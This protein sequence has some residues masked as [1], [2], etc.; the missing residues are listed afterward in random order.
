MSNPYGGQ[1]PYGRPWQPSSPQPGPDAPQSSNG[2]SPQ[3]AA[4]PGQA[5]AAQPGYPQP[6]GNS[7]PGYPQ[8]GYQQPGY[9]QPHNVSSPGIPQPGHPQQGVPQPGYP[10]PGTSQPGYPQQG[11]P[12]QGYDQQGTS[13][14]GYPQQGVPQQ[15]YPQQGYGAPNPGVPQ[16]FGGAPANPYPYPQPNYVAPQGAVFQPQPGPPGIVVESSYYPLQILLALSSPRILLN[17]QEVPGSRWGTTHI[18]VGAGQYHVQVKTKWLW[19]YGPG[20]AVVPVADGQSTKVYYR[21]PVMWMFQGAI[22]PVPQKTPGVTAMYIIWG[23][24]AALILLELIV[25]LAA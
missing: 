8:V 5:A 24:V 1:S 16:Q 20:D 3:S 11:V 13:Q 10:Q 21:S 12:Q 25:G 2:H 9:P 6:Q 7:T 22:G 17:G 23:I 18:P 4:Q 14:P 15:G 19:D